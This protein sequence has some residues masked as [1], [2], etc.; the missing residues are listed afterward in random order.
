[1]TEDTRWQDRIRGE[2]EARRL[3]AKILG[4]DET[5]SPEE[6]KRAWRRECRRTHPDQNPG[7]PDAPM[8][9]RMVNCAYRFLT[10]GTP[11]EEL[12]KESPETEHSPTDRK[13]DLDNRWGMFLWWR[14][15]FF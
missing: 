6:I 1:M 5:A 13:Y 8:K 3:A 9:F 12:F 2:I 14:D 7:V 4:V 10:E 15:R 11:C